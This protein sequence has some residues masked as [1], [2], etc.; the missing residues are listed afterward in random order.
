M[1]CILNIDR[2]TLPNDIVVLL[3]KIYKYGF[4]NWNFNWYINDF[5]VCNNR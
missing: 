4:Y 2:F 3:T 1:S 5:C